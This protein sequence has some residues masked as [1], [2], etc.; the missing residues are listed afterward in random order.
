MRFPLLDGD[1]ARINEPLAT[2]MLRRAIDNG[3]NY[4]DTAYPYHAENFHTGGASEPFLGKA[5][6]DGYRE[7]VY[8]ATKL[9]SWLVKSREDMDRF[10]DEQLERLATSHIDFYLLH[11]MNERNWRVLNELG[12]FDF[13]ER[14]LESGKIRHIG[15]SFHD[16]L[17]LFREIVDARDW[18]FCQV[19]Y[20]YYDEHYQ[21]GREGLE[22]AASKGLGTV[23]M[24]PL[25]GGSLIRGLPA[26]ARRVF[27]EAAPGRSEAGWA[28]GWLWEQDAVEVVLSGMSTMEQVEENLDLAT[29]RWDEEWGAPD[30]HAVEKASGVI[31]ELQK[32]NCTACAYC[33]PCPH[34]VNIPRNFSLCND[35]HML[36]DPAARNRYYGFLSEK[37]RASAC[38]Q[39]GECLEKCPQH[40]DIPEELSHV[41]DI[42]EKQQ[43]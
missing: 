8:L 38:V 20:N 34:G 5:L 24:E 14:A 17:P 33:M 41:V 11:S 9:P 35:H 12:V 37:Q 7:K 21:A 28:L 40:I 18:D 15:F 3:V 32:V 23:V 13:I 39:C 16:E 42:F 29:T 22:Y 43:P 30:A 27:K 36:D 10:L 1:N 19:M 25:R 4:I 31:H 2:A 6:S 26:E